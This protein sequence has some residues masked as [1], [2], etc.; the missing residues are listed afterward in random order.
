MS[1][2]KTTKLKDDMIKYTKP[3]FKVIT[4][5]VPIIITGC[6]KFWSYYESLPKDYIELIIGIIFCFFGGI[7]PALFAAIE[8]AKNGGIATVVEALRD[9]G[10]EAMNIIEANKKDDKVDENE[11]GIS[12]VDQI[13]AKDLLL[14]KANLVVTKMN[15][16]KIDKALS[17]IY[18]V[19]LSVVA[20]LTF[21]FAR[22]IN[23]GVSISEFLKKPAMHYLTPLAN[24]LMPKGYAKWV[25]TLI[26]WATRFIGMSFAWWISSIMTAFASAL[27]GALKISRAL[28]KIARKKGITL[29]GMIPENHEETFIDEAASYFFAL[30]G[31]WIQFKVNFNI[32]FPINLF[33]LPMEMGEF[34][35]RWSVTKLS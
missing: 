19:W 1:E 29:N 12:D 11:D 24:D 33:F 10:D 20:V 32:P 14:R 6:Q 9:L 23:M 18:T 4:T 17:S 31:L 16:A 8:A 21:Q 26:G 25:P 13:S 27:I 7:F 30:F 5:I 22:I 3:G 28:M 34:F 15:P 2:T 35:V